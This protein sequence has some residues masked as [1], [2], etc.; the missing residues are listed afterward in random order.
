MNLRQREY[1]LVKQ[2]GE[3]ESEYLEK[4]RPIQ[5]ELDKLRPPT[6]WNQGDYI[7]GPGAPGIFGPFLARV[8]PLQA[9]GFLSF[10]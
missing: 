10:K 6:T 8:L 7:A 2:L 4:V 3:L 9:F 1:E 5:R